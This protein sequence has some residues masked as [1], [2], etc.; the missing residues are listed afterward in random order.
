[1]E[2]KHYEPPE[3][4]PDKVFEITPEPDT[5]YSELT[6]TNAILNYRRKKDIRDYVKHFNKIEVGNEC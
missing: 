5:K 4:E 3:P 2:I 1:M 6:Y